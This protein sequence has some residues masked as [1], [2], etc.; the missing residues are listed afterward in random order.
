MTTEP[1]RGRRIPSVV[2][3]LAVPVV[4]A[5]AAFGW[6]TISPLFLS[7]QV[8]EAFPTSAP[9]AA[10]AA[11]AAAAPTAA[12]TTAPA[13][14]VATEAPAPTEVP[15]A[16]VATEASAPTAAAAATEAPAPTAA[17]APTE[18]PA[19]TAAPAEPV[20][21][22]RGSFTF[23]DNLHWAE[24]AATIYRLADGSHVLRLEPFTAQ[25]GPDL[26]VGISGHPMPRT[27]DE[28]Y[29]AG[30]VELA[31]LKANQGNQNYPIPADVDLSAF[32]SVV[33]YCKAFSVVF[34]TAELVAEG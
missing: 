5:I 1:A 26:F 21:L 33:I 19:P 27:N 11:P 6:W 25:N 8:D 34:S 16:V 4:L 12:P 15:A 31:R 7:S 13:A 22:S 14:V 10:T 18:A 17:P 9:A 3:W 20:A 2:R 30:Y 23:L 28:T 24:G 29:G 32:K